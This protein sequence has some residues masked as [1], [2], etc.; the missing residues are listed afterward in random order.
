MSDPDNP[1]TLEALAWTQHRT[2]VVL[3]NVSRAVLRETGLGFNV[4]AARDWEQVREALEQVAA[5]T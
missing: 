2:V 3:G 4:L 5:A 1:A